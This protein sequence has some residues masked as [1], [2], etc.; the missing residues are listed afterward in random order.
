[1]DQVLAVLLGTSECTLNRPW[2]DVTAHCPPCVTCSGRSLSAGPSDSPLLLEPPWVCCWRT[3]AD[4]GG[5]HTFLAYSAGEGLTGQEF[6]VLS[7]T[8]IPRAACS[9]STAGRRG[10]S[11]SPSLQGLHGRRHSLLGEAG[12]LGILVFLFRD[13]RIL[14][15]T[16]RVG[17][18]SGKVFK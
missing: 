6:P 13:P 5:R 18:L 1:M 9:S 7:M 11:I 16:L 10:S 15:K 3:Q 14:Q 17:L 4:L 8:A 2:H 12:F